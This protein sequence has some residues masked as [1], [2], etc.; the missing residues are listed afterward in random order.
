M[1]GTS[2]WPKVVIARTPKGCRVSFR[3]TRPTSGCPAADCADPALYE[4]TD[5]YASEGIAKRFD[6]APG[7]SSLVSS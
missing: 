3:E 4:L 2:S 6:L 7:A 1:S 5:I